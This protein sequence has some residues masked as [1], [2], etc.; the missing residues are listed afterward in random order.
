M[1]MTEILSYTINNSS[2]RHGAKCVHG[3]RH[4]CCIL[5]HGVPKKQP[6]N[7]RSFFLVLFLYVS[8]LPVGNEHIGFAFDFSETVGSKDQFFPV[9][10]KHGKTIKTAIVCN[11]LLF[12]RL[13]I[14]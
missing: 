8:P 4:Q 7:D 9:V 5:I 13:D 10:G 14:D 6:C 3:V 1:F 2:K 12:S 11:A